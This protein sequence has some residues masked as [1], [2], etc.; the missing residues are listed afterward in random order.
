MTLR[1]LDQ[2]NARDYARADHRDGLPMAE[3][4]REFADAL[5]A[6]LQEAGIDHE[7]LT[8]WYRFD[9]SVP[10]HQTLSEHGYRWIA[11]YPVTGGSE[12]HY[13]HVDAILQLQGQ[14]R[15][16]PLFL[17]KTFAGHA[18]ARQIADACARILGS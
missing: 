8:S 1:S 11:C 17:I 16:V 4:A 3:L 7:G 5:D 13:V 10:A 2:Q 12:G 14:S 15:I 9:I 18:A 6:T